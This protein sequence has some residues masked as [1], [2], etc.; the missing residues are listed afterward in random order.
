MS[1]QEYYEYCFECECNGEI[2]LS[3]EDVSPK[4]CAPSRIWVLAVCG[5]TVTVKRVLRGLARA[6]S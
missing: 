4:C 3:F 6:A 2:P 1:K 5:Q